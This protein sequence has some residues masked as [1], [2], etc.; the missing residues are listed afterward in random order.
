MKN[1]RNDLNRE[2]G[3]AMP[4]RRNFLAAALAVGAASLLGCS[5]RGAQEEQAGRSAANAAASP[6][7][8]ARNR[9]R[10]GSLEVSAIGLGC[11]NLAWGFGPPIDRQDAVRLIRA[12]YDRGVTFFDTA[13]VY[14]PFLSEEIVG[15]A[16]APVRDRVV[17]ATKFGFDIAPSGQIRG[18]NSRPEHIRQVAEASLRRLRTDRID[19]LYQHRVDPKVP[20][21]DVAGAVK[22]LM[23]EGKARHFGLSEAGG[24]TI[25]RAHAVQPVTAVQNE[26]SVWS[27]DPEMEVIPT[28]EELGIGLVPWGP[29]GKGYLTG[30]ITPST[31]FQAGDLRATLP[32]LTPEARRTNWPVVE[33]LQRV[34]KRKE[35]TPGQVALAWLLA[36][37]PWV[38]PIPGTTKLNHMEQNTDALKV[39][40]TAADVKEIEDGFAKIRVQGARS[41]EAILAQTDIGAKLGTTSIGGHGMSPLLRKPTQ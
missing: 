16:L 36:R 19:L 13:E 1:I 35:A 9:R 24:A 17:I 20:I 22:Q 14:G 7:T 12:A 11:M 8:A 28:C 2:H 33:L 34:G 38:V 31:T 37:K 15:E 10:L 27:R 23:Q 18:V 5:D 21:E 39:E 3:S 6:V 40:L 4:D 41:S 29:L 30:T 26:Y 25:R 32:R